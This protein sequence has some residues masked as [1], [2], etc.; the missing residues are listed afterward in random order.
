MRI[1][2]ASTWFP[3]PPDNGAKI[4]AF[5][6]VRHLALRHEV[7]LLAFSTEEEETHLDVL[8]DICSSVQVVRR[9]PFVMGRMG[10][11]LG[12]LSLR[13]RGVVSSYSRAMEQAVRKVTGHTR[14]DVLVG[15]CA[16][17]GRY[18]TQVPVTPRVLEEQNSGTRMMWEAYRGETRAAGRLRRWVAYQKTLHY[19]RWLFRQFDAVS[20]VSEPDRGAVLAAMP[21]MAGRV[22]V[23]PNGADL[24]WNRPGLAIPT[25]DTL[26]FNGPLTYSANADA[27]R[28]FVQEVLPLVRQHRP[29]VTLTITGRVEGV[30]L[31]WVPADGGV[32]LK[33]YLDDVRPAVAGAWTCVVPLRLGGGTRL[34][35]LEALAL[36]TP[37]VSTAKGAEGLDLV[38]GQ[39]ILI[40][41]G[42]AELA[43]ATLRL[44]R[45]PSLRERLSAAGRRA[46]V[47]RYGW[48]E[49]G[50]RM[51]RWLTGIAAAGRRTG[52]Q[53]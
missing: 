36:G 47:D 17:A 31:S 25:P 15:A 38:P 52:S 13:P 50:G 53:A 32:V 23:V 6:L 51:D 2:Y 28:S 33:G 39:E 24:E 3:Y 40:A 27:M 18:L 12:F 4:R 29:E 16:P 21:D 34:K 35:I 5:N 37:V 11:V 46:V 8:R 30:D 9:D 20:M 26:V 19:E 44:L 10:A 7:H 49:I 41:D 22:E 48:A 45:E 1:L 14:F 43:E 42:P